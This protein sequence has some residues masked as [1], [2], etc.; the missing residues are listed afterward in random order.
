MSG[1]HQICCWCAP[2]GFQWILLAWI[3]IPPKLKTKTKNFV[4]KTILKNKINFK[5]L[6]KC[7][8]ILKQK[9]VFV[10]HC[11]FT[12][13]FL[14][15]QWPDPH[16]EFGCGWIRISITVHYI[17]AGLHK[18]T[19]INILTKPARRF[20]KCQKYLQYMWSTVQGAQQLLRY[21]Y[22]YRQCILFK[23][24]VVWVATCMAIP[25]ELIKNFKITLFSMPKWQ[26]TEKKPFHCSSFK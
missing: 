6:Y 21:V 3:P 11:L 25:F 12:T 19:Y 15:N 8:R 17:C 2:D 5:K 9:Q 10:F 26:K 7:C 1:F 24:I 18:T 13:I 20:R 16:N 23:K 22:I 4:Y 14:V